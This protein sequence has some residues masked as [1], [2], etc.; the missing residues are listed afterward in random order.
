VFCE[1][2]HFYFSQEKQEA[3]KHRHMQAFHDQL[4][5]LRAEAER[6]AREEAARLR[7]TAPSPS[8]PRRSPERQQVRRVAARPKPA[9]PRKTTPQPSTVSWKYFVACPFVIRLA[10]NVLK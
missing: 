9:S 3:S 1:F 7:K 2:I 5:A 4:V 10:R 8:P 6:E